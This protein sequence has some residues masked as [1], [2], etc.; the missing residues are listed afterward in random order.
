MEN[1]SWLYFNTPYYLPPVTYPLPDS[2][3]ISTETPDA[4]Q[5][6]NSD[7]LIIE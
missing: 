4:V 7:L 6:E 5:M 1:A 2:Y 3:Y